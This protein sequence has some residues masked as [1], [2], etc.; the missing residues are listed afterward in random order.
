M[1]LLYITSQIKGDGG[2][3]RIMAIKTNYFIENFGYKIDI[4]APDLGDDLFFDFNKSIGFH[5]IKSKPKKIARLLEY[6]KQVQ[7]HIN[8]HKQKVIITDKELIT[9]KE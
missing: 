7:K 3:Q 8:S 4:L 1:K 9:R 2:L 5:F 6:K